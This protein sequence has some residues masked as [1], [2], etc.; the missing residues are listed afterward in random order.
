MKSLFMFVAAM[1]LSIVSVGAQV[2]VV[3]ATNQTPISAASVFDAVGNMVGFTW[4][5]G[6]LSDIPVTEYPLTVRCMGYEPITI[7]RAEDKAWPMNP[8]AYELEEVVIVPVKRNVLKQIFYVREYFSMSSQKDTMTIFKEHM[9]DRFV[10][11]SKD[12]KFGGDASLRILATRDYARFKFSEKDSVV[13]ESEKPFPSML[14]IFDLEEEEVKAPESF[15]TSTSTN[16][17]HE[18]QGKSGPVSIYKQND[19]TFTEIIDILAIKKSHTWSPWPLKLLG[20]TMEAK[21]F[22]Y[23]QTYRV[24]D[25]GVYYPKDFLE[26]SFV[27]EADGR[28]K[29]F[30]KILDSDKP[31]MIR[32]MIELYVVD[33]EYLSKEEAKD[34]YKHK[35]TNV[36]FQIPSTIPGLNKATQ[37]LI[38][39]AHAEKKKEK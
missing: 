29:N 15:L 9:A 33:R 23:H 38:D 6:T 30:R 35:P 36:S 17:I 13:C 18:E 10:P 34:E 7:D 2:R 8:I 39:R 11:T 32:T 1:L 3:D 25:K 22:Y 24:N 12:A 20:Y 21:Q 28:G 14:P 19:Q 27:M 5:D 26:G 4:G 37:D 16:K 31:I